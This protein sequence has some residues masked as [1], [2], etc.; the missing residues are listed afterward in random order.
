VLSRSI[1]KQVTQRFGTTN[2]HGIA[3]VN[4]SVVP[5]GFISVARRFQH[6]IQAKLRLGK[7]TMSLD[8]PSQD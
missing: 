2:S 3:L 4:C 5:S 6:A 7:L 1:A 8:D